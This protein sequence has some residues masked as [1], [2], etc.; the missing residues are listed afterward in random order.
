MAASVPEHDEGQNARVGEGLLDGTGKAYRSFI[1][2]VG[3]ESQQLVQLSSKDVQATVSTQQ[4]C[5]SIVGQLAKRPGKSGMAR[6]SGNR[7]PSTLLRR[8]GAWAAL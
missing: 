2:S 1:T 5:S 3:T 6:G 8:P 4:A 7:K